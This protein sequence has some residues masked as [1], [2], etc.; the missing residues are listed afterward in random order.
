MSGDSKLHLVNWAK[1]CKPI[2]V[3]ELGI[4]RLRSFN[5]ALLGKWLWR[6]GLDTDMLWRRVIEAIE[7]GSYEGDRAMEEGY[8]YVMEE[9][10]EGVFTDRV[11][12]FGNQEV[13]A[14]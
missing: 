3:G 12:W 1:V 14:F 4:R 7:S 13:S 9:G 5:F 11:K 8:R 6:S 10:Y 2:Q